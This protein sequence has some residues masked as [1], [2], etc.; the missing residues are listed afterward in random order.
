LSRYPEGY[1]RGET[2]ANCEGMEGKKGYPMTSRLPLISKAKYP[3][4]F[5]SEKEDLA[6]KSVFLLMRAKDAVQS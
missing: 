5:I 2:K 4:L 6:A 1:K 3:I